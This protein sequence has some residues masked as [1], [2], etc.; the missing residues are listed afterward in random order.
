MNRVDIPFSWERATELVQ[1]GIKTVITIGKVDTGKSTLCKYLTHTWV[2]SG[3]KVGYV[4]SDIGQSTIGPPTTIGFK[5]FQ[6]QYNS[7]DFT[8]PTSIQFVGNTSP[9]GF[10][11]QTLYGV[12]KMVD[13]SQ[14]LEV[15]AT[16]V[17]TT[18]FVDG[19]AARILKMYKIEMIRPQCIIALQV[20]DEIEHLLKGYEKMGWRVLRLTCS[21]LAIT[22]SQAERVRFRNKRYRLYFKSAKN[23][24][25]SIRKIVFPS[26]ILGTGE[27]LDI[28]NTPVR[29]YFHHTENLYVE[30]CGND[31]LIIGDDITLTFPVYRLRWYFD[32]NTIVYISRSEMRDLLVGLNDTHG[33]TLGIGTITDLNP[34]AEKLTI[35]TPIQNIDDISTIHMGTIRL[36]HG[37]REYGRVRIFRYM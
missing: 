12:K 23:V 27:R 36:A 31:L 6:S 7:H 11:L 1:H 3:M 20:K 33:N 16:L 9:E 15:D 18:G 21:K 29:N 30:K 4:D 37:E 8:N 10:L 19:P 17:D 13:E 34:F 2:T 5:V 25:C 35:F 26:C 28:S 24:E 32:A 14:R 22:R